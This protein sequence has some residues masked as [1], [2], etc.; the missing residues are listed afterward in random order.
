MSSRIKTAFH[1]AT[2]EHARTAPYTVADAVTDYIE[3]RK[4][5]GAKTAERMG[6]DFNARVIPALGTIP[7]D[8][9]TRKR[10]EIWM[11]EVAASPVRRRGKEG[12]PPKGPDEIRA[13]KSSANR[14]WKMLHAAL[15]LAFKERKV[16]TDEGWRNLE[17]FKGTVSARIRFLNPSEQVR[18]VNACSSPDF[19]R[20][21]QAGLFTGARESELAALKAKD[22]D[23]I[24][25][26][27]FIEFSKSGR[28]RHITLTQESINFFLEM[29]AGAPPETALF[30]RESYD[31]KQKSPSGTWSRAELSRT[32]GEACKE[33]GL[34]PMVFHELRHTYASGLVNKGVALVFVAQQL[35]HRDISM[36]ERHYGHLCQS[37]KVDAVRRLAPTLGIHQVGGP[38]T[39]KIQG[40]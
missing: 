6:Y 37:A 14:L 17:A 16:T 40:S 36:V 9:L 39:L 21:V 29:V 28:S 33:A 1:I 22:F 27:I 18:L 10:L 8:R 32:M 19:R 24:N 2:G 30:R 3:D 7:V 13:R 26:S 25:G 5:N 12:A 20:L 34:E 31:R 15:N 38:V 11:D 35:G 23:P 4:R